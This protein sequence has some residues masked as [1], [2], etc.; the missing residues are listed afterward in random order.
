MSRKIPFGVTGTVNV[1]AGRI[2]TFDEI[3]SFRPPYDLPCIINECRIVEDESNNVAISLGTYNGLL[4]SKL[5]LR[6]GKTFL[7]PPERAFIL[8]LGKRGFNQDLGSNV[9]RIGNMDWKF[10]QGLF[11]PKGVRFF[12]DVY[13]THSVATTI[14]IGLFGYAIEEI[15]ADVRVSKVPYVATWKAVGSAAGTAVKST[16]MELVNPFR[17][18]LYVTALQGFSLV[19]SGAAGAADYQNAD[20][21]DYVR[22]FR[23]DGNAIVAQDAPLA[24]VFCGDTFWWDVDFVL[25]PG[26][27]VY[28]W[29]NDDVAAA[30]ARI[31]VHGYREVPVSEL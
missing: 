29:L 27:A 8:N 23:E 18:P 3:T 24:A 21:Y 25:Q 26:E 17:E 12:A 9:T 31:A 15:D 19:S 30:S 1:G 20:W 10:K 4:Y 28:M 13:N 16:K 7:T 5:G 14:H 22:I 2:K 6:L 11:V